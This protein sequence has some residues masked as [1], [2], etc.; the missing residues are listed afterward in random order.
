MIPGKEYT[1][2]S[3][4]WLKPY[5]NIQN[6]LYREKYI[7]IELISYAECKDAEK[8]VEYDINKF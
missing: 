6:W 1:T 4:N 3:F 8:I 7:G 2:D 5:I